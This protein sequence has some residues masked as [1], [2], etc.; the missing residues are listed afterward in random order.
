MGGTC[1]RPARHAGSRRTRPG[2]PDYCCRRRGRCVR[3]SRVTDESAEVRDRERSDPHRQLLR[4]LRR[5]AVGGAGDGRGRPDRRAHRR[6]AGRADDADPVQ[7]PSA[8]RPG[9]GYARTF[10]TQMEQV[11]GTCLDRGIKVVANAG[12]L[13]PAGCAERGARGRRPARPGADDRLRRG[14]RPACARARRAA[15]PATLRPPR[16]R[17]AARR[18]R[19]RSSRANAYLGVLGHRRGARRGR[20]RRRSPAASPTP[21]SSCGPAAWHHGWARDRLGRARRRRRRR[22]R[23]RVRRAGDR[24]QLLVLHRGA[25]H[26][27]PLGFPIA[28]VAADGSSVITKHA[29][30]GGEVSIG[31]VTVAAAVR[32]RRPRVP[33]PRRRSPAST[34]SGSSRTAPTGCASRGVRGEPPPPTLKVAINYARRL[35]QPT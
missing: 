9:G 2:S 14:R 33:Q 11:L 15:P 18:R 13:D 3:S 28:E 30:T 6:L 23:H 34:P 10:L 27:E 5:P 25:R 7:G 20:R 24:R 1:R 17:R 29:G 4:L 32:D 26:V 19:P 16:H 31:T 22:P 35:P 12:G 21:P 8:K